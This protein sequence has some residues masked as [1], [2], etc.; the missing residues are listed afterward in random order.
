MTSPRTL[1]AIVKVTAEIRPAATAR[2]SMTSHTPRPR[3]SA[4]A[5]IGSH[6]GRPARRARESRQ[7]AL[8][9]ESAR[10]SMVTA[11]RKAIAVTCV[12]P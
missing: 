10:M 3:A 2:P 8:S 5:G 11:V 12:Q 6:L 9:R 7:A 1:A 4:P